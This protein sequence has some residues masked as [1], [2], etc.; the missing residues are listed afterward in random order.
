[1]DKQKPEFVQDFTGSYQP[2][3]PNEVVLIMNNKISL[4]VRMKEWINSFFYNFRRN[5]I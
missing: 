4:L 3:K 2:R 1:M 5:L